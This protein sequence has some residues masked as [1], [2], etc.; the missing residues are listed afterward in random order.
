[1]KTYLVRV[2]DTRSKGDCDFL[3]LFIPSIASSFL[4]T[5]PRSWTV[6]S[7]LS[8]GQIRESLGRWTVDLPPI[9]EDVAEAPAGHLV[10]A[11]FWRF[12]TMV[13]L[14]AEISDHREAA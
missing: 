1:M 4:R 12:G 2:A 9:V 7:V 10:S 13:S 14:D 8:A 3:A 11:E 5:G 6:T